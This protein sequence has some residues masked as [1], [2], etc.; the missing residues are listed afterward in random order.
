MLRADPRSSPK[1]RD[2]HIPYGCS[3]KNTRS[4]T[5]RMFAGILISQGA[6]LICFYSQETASH[7]RQVREYSDRE[8]TQMLALWRNFLDVQ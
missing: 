8:K 6:D 5:S 4:K 2:K 1:Q 3:G 7:V